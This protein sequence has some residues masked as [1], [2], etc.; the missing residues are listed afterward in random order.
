MYCCC[1]WIVLID[2][3]SE[4]IKH[5]IE[6]KF[7]DVC[8]FNNTVYALSYEDGS[9]LVKTVHVWSMNGHKIETGL[10]KISDGSTCVVTQS[11]IYIGNNYDAIHEF[12]VNGKKVNTL[13]SNARCPKICAVNEAAEVMVIN[14]TDKV[15]IISSKT[16]LTAHCVD[17][18][19]CLRDI[20]F[21]DSKTFWM[22]DRI[23][24]SQ[25]KYRLIKGISE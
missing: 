2:F 8:F 14:S 17:G 7:A 16:P 9:I 20:A 1:K 23:E 15:Y 4:E 6:G 18:V 3:H 25:H 19:T 11:S 24:P 13:R 21:Q 10:E 5:V 22:L 12:S